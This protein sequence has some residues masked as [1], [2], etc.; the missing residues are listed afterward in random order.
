MKLE[1]ITTI[2]VTEKEWDTLI[3]AKITL[4]QLFN[5]L[6]NHEEKADLIRKALISLEVVMNDVIDDINYD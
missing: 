1:I 4:A 2:N 3:A 6:Q 5:L